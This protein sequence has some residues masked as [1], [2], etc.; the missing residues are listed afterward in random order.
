MYII[1][2]ILLILYIILFYLLFKIKREYEQ[3][4]TIY[5]SHLKNNSKNNTNSKRENDSK[6]NN[7]SNIRDNNI[8]DNNINENYSEDDKEII[9]SIKE[10]YPKF[11]SSKQYIIC[12]LKWG[13]GNRIK[14]LVS[15]ILLSR[16][17]NCELLVVWTNHDMD[18]TKI[19]D[20]WKHPY[21]FVV[22]PNLPKG[23]TIPVAPE[24]EWNDPSLNCWLDKYDQ[25]IISGISIINEEHMSRKLLFINTWWFFKPDDLSLQEFNKQ[26]RYILENGLIPT[27]NIKNLCKK[28]NNLINNDTIGVHIRLSDSCQVLW[29][30]KENCDKLVYNFL[31]YIDGVMIDPKTNLFLCTDDH[32]VLTTLKSKYNGRI[33]I[34]NLNT[35]RFTKQ[36]QEESY[37]EILTLAKCNRLCLTMSSTFSGIVY[38][39]SDLSSNTDDKDS[40][41]DDKNN[42][43]TKGCI[44]ISPNKTEVCKSVGYNL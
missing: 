17:L 1:I 6:E 37:A 28:Y 43:N 13:L 33:K 42:D 32:E 11:D 27:D 2:T 12:V 41:K 40:N 10:M 24:Q 29:K 35:N 8:R 5:T 20:I 21:P 31:D 39:I 44:V 22:L 15:S 3:S 7:K 19:T 9:E 4:F 16:Y 25:C 14:C 23:Y 26:K 36:G 34:P 18:N 38:D 30:T